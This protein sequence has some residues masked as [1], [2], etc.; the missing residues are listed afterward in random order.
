MV[1]S[2]GKRWAKNIENIGNIFKGYLSF[3][4]ANNINI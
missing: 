3:G 1:N 4:W 2:N